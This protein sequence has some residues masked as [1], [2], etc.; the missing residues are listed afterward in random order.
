MKRL[1]VLEKVVQN[2]IDGGPTRRETLV[3]FAER[4]GAK[5]GE[6]VVDGLLGSGD[7]VVI[8]WAR[9]ARLGTPAQARARSAP[10]APKKTRV[11]QG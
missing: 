8:G 6:M 10:P 4:H 1:A 2:V 9:G 3:H 7:L 5:D 11:L